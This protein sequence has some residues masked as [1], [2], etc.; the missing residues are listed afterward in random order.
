MAGVAYIV[1]AGL[2]GNQ[3]LAGG[4]VGMDF[5]VARPIKV[6]KLGV[7]D[8]GS[9]GLTMT[10]SAVLYDRAARKSLA[11]LDFTTVNQGELVDGS[12]F[13][14]L[15]EPLVLDDGFQGS[16]V[17]WY[18]NGTTE[19]LFNTFG[20]PDP[21]IADLRVFDGGSLLFV[22]AGRYGSAGQ[23]PGTVDGG[24]VNRYAVATFAVE[25]LTLI[26]RPIIQ[27][28]R[29]GD[30]LKLSW[31]GGGG[32]EKGGNFSGKEQKVAGAAARGELPLSSGGSALFRL[33]P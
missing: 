7:F 21:A 1:P 29:N 16:I 31:N 14:P 30:K 26:E 22:G 5:D 15:G 17:I 9:D 12:R 25:P 6:T 23:F 10:L 20:N 19:R 3:A 4:A 13:L 24:P 28:V 11:T 27:F 8:D 33:H 32:L 18:S 2:A